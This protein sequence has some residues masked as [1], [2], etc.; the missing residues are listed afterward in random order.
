MKRL[1]DKKTAEELR[2]KKK[3]TPNQEIYLALYEKENAEEKMTAE[4]ALFNKVMDAPN[5]FYVKFKYDKCSYI[6]HV[7]FDHI[8][9]SRVIWYDT[10]YYYVDNEFL[11]KLCTGQNGVYPHDYGKTWAF[12]K[13]ELEDS[14]TKKAMAE[15]YAKQEAKRNDPIEQFKE[16]IA[17]LSSP[18]ARKMIAELKADLKRVKKAIKHNNLKYLGAVSGKFGDAVKEISDLRKQEELLTK[19]LELLK[20]FY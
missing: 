4:T 11:P 2:A 19:K 18:D 5:G 3:L 12:T 20:K 14:K 8:T 10:N 17:H 6:Y 1:T 13:E 16:S 15:A 7:R 9:Q